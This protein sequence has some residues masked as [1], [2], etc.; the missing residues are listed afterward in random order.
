MAALKIPLRSYRSR[1]ELKTKVALAESDFSHELGYVFVAPAARKA[2]LG[3]RLCVCLISGAK[4]RG[5][6]ATARTS[7]EGMAR[8]LADL[9]FA[10]SGLAY[11]S[12]RAEYDLQLYL[13]R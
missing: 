12:R 8:I 10:R 13:R 1:I 5:I 2:G 3:K 9:G 11:E 6:F 4:Q 7:N